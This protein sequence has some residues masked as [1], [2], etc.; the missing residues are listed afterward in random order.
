M[1]LIISKTPN[2]PDRLFNKIEKDQHSLYY[3]LFLPYQYGL[4]GDYPIYSKEQI[5]EA[6]KSPDFPR[7]YIHRLEL[8]SQLKIT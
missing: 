1:I 8:P 4:E 5:E 3:K 7:E 6:R 2:R